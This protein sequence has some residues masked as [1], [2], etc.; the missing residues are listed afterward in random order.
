MDQVSLGAPAFRPTPPAGQPSPAS[1]QPS[2]QPATVASAAAPSPPAASSGSGIGLGAIIGIVVGAVV[3]LLIA[4][5]PPVVNL[6]CFARTMY[7]LDMF[8]WPPALEFA[9]VA[10]A[11]LHATQLSLCSF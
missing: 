8:G 7:Q 6:D 1:G 9:I 3:A 4:G 2:G 11:C 10:R 5:V